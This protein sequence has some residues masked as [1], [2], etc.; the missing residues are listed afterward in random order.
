[1]LAAQLRN[2]N[3]WYLEKVSLKPP[4][5]PLP[6]GETPSFSLVSVQLGSRCLRYTSHFQRTL[7][8]IG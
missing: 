7:F 6:M 8:L 1:M 5:E 4:L 2:F 3:G